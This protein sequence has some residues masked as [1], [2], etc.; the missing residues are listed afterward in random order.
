MIVH[1]TPSH[2]ILSKNDRQQFSKVPT[3][4]SVVN[5]A[6]NKKIKNVQVVVNNNS[7]IHSAISLTNTNIRSLKITAP[8]ILPEGISNDYTTTSQKLPCILVNEDTNESIQIENGIYRMRRHATINATTASKYNLKDQQT[9]AVKIN[10]PRNTTTF[11]DMYVKVQSG[12]ENGDDSIQVYL[13]TDETGSCVLVDAVS[14]DLY[15]QSYDGNNMIQLTHVLRTDAGVAPVRQDRVWSVEEVD[16]EFKQTFPLR[17]F[18][19][20]NTKG[21]QKTY[22]IADDNA[23]SFVLQ[24]L[25]S[26]KHIHVSPEDLYAM[27]GD[28]HR[29]TPMKPIGG[30][31][32]MI[33]A[34]VFGF[35]SKEKLTIRNIETGQELNNVTILGPPRVRTQ[36]ELAYS[37][38]V[39]VGLQNDTPTRI[40]GDNLSSGKCILI[41]HNDDGSLNEEGAINLKQGAV[42]AWRHIHYAGKAAQGG[43]FMTV[44]VESEHCTTMFHDILVRVGQDK[45]DANAPDPNPP[46]W[47]KAAKYA[48]LS[49]F[50]PVFLMMGGSIG[51]NS[52]MIHVDTDEGNACNIGQAKG[53][54]LYN[55]DLKSG[56]LKFIGSTK[57]SMAK[58]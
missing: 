14:Y 43:D 15:T 13:D 24:T 33:L 56:E 32:P 3:T 50:M 17:T 28:G 41:P 2:I 27:F 6:N 20:G 42:R 55:Q 49:I 21:S 57:N 39:D 1:P 12:N 31:V 46:F 35:A 37:D 47:M 44:C 48:A 23:D 4:L 30:G 16:R 36:I 54:T 45:R 10:S 22:S 9:V 8:L 38:L 51:F 34:R 25:V 52:N 5:P 18:P 26:N 7:V 29:L 19:I 53:F 11:C 58:M 40:S